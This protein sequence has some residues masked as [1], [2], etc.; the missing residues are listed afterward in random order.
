M[1]NHLPTPAPSPPPEGP[2]SIS[3]EIN[4]ATRK[5][6]TELN[7]L[8]IER[9]P[10]ALPPHASDPALLGQGLATFSQTFF[11]F[12]EVWQQIEDGKHALSRYD[13]DRAQEYD[14]VSSL[15]F[16]R[17][18]GLARSERLRK[19]LEYISKRTGKGVQRTGAVDKQL[20]QQIQEIV[21]KK[22]HVLIAYAWVMY[23]AIFSGGRWIRQQLTNAGPEF[24]T[25]EP[26]A[27][28]DEKKALMGTPAL[29]G[30]SFLSF[31]GEQD[32]EDIKAEFKSRLA[33]TEALLTE[34]ERQDVIEAAQELFDHCI[35]LVGD[36]DKSVA[37]QRATSIVAP[38]L[39]LTLLFVLV[40]GLYWFD[41]YGYLR[42]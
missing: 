25:G 36:L 26:A 40:L 24:W 15:A 39:L 11:A 5:H 30:F 29:P 17:P 42:Q 38:A 12:E 9:L 22:P 18:I 33:E 37:R 23:M 21:N 13:P 19:D 34:N 41:N 31:E 14:V 28:T 7:R 16:L 32:G 6:H 10:L 4:K 8:I 27:A 3:A 20:A 35:R 2:P 1:A